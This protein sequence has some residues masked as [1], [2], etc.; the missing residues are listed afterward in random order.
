MNALLSFLC[1]VEA[2]S[3]KLMSAVRAGSV[4]EVRELVAKKPKLAWKSQQWGEGAHDCRTAAT[5]ANI[6]VHTESSRK[7]QH[8][9]A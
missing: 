5:T 9:R 4:A 2:D 7:P 3:Y 1:C 6:G 8:K